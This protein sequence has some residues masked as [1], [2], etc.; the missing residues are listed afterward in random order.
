[1][2]ELSGELITVACKPGRSGTIVNRRP[3]WLTEPSGENLPAHL[4]VDG[5]RL[6]VSHRGLNRITVFSLTTDVPTPL[7]EIETG[8]WPRH[9]ALRGGWLY[10]ADQLDD[11]ITAK[12]L[13]SSGDSLETSLHTAMR[14]PSCVLPL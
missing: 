10:I 4:L 14:R 2:G 7:T 12:A 9:F 13:T 5:D 8:A 1:L 11:R 6:Y 3:A